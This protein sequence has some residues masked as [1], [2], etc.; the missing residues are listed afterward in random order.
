MKKLLSA[1][2]ARLC[3]GRVFWLADALM[4]ALVLL[5]CIDHYHY[6]GRE[7]ILDGFFLGYLLI[8]GFPLSVV[9]GLYLGTEY[10]DGTVRNK[11]IAG[12]TRGAVYLA[13]L[14]TVFCAALVM[15]FM[16][17]ITACVVGIPLFGPL[18]SDWQFILIMLGESILTMGALAAIFTLVGHLIRNRAVMAVSTVL[19]TFFLFFL[20]VSVEERLKESEFICMGPLQSQ[21]EVVISAG[22]ESEEAEF[23]PNPSFLTG[24]KRELYVFFRDF[25]PFGQALQISNMFAEHPGH[26]WQM[27]LYSLLII[28]AATG[29][30]L[31]MFGRMD[32]R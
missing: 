27:P 28:A 24:K 15:S 12:H 17:V 7:T 4:I 31:C 21:D 11:L 19:L 5:I 26:L 30:G 13:N 32:I 18:K 20:A 23:I 1:N 6:M 2:F 29:V 10:G 25:N 8:V 22:E 14:I 3:A 16:F 9:S